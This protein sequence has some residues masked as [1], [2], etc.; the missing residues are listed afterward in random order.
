MLW[1]IRWRKHESFSV[2]EAALLA[3]DE[4]H[5]LLPAWF[6]AGVV[7]VAVGV[8]LLITGSTSGFIVCGAIGATVF[9]IRWLLIRKWSKLDELD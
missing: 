4:L 1:W 6:V 7:F 8:L 5:I 2:I 3:L 9:C